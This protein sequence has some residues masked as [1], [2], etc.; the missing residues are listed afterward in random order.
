LG[1]FAARL[2]QFRLARGLTQRVL[3]ER[4]GISPAHY[5]EIAHAQANPTL[6][7]SL[8]LADAVEVSIAELLAAPPASGDHRFVSA[9]E[10]RALAAAVRPLIQHL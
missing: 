4:A 8:R 3:S 5:Q 10:L 7:V 6:L 1:A 9:E 2:E